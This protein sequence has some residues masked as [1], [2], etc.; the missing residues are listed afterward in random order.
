MVLLLAGGIA[1][2]NYRGTGNPFTMPYMVYIRSYMTAPELLFLPAPPRPVF[3]H[4][5]LART[6]AGRPASLSVIELA[7]NMR[8]RVTEQGRQFFGAIPIVIAVAALLPLERNAWYHLA[9]LSLALFVVSMGTQG[10]MWSHYAAPAVGLALLLVMRAIRRTGVWRPGGVRLGRALA[11]AGWLF[12]AVS[13]T[14]GSWHVIRTMPRSGWP[15]A[16]AAIEASLSRSGAKHLV[17]VR[18]T[19]RYPLGWEWIYNAADI[20]AAPVVWAADMDAAS[21]GRLFDYYKD[22]RI[23]LLEPDR[24]PI[25]PVPYPMGSAQ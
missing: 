16:R 8:E 18:Y 4:E 6:F 24:L 15:Y 22:R 3:R 23:W 1:Y 10:A 9:L 12:M 7:A 25:E 19:P 11:R 2:Y 13:L 21:N 20:D 5:R 14:W 17:M